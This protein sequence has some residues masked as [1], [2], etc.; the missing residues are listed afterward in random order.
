MNPKFC[1]FNVSIN[2]LNNRHAIH[3]YF[4]RILLLTLC[5][6]VQTAA[7]YVTGLF[8]SMVPHVKCVG[9]EFKGYTLTEVHVT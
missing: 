6:Q 5:L 9:H 7:S 3:T 8:I 2:F 1:D 4:V